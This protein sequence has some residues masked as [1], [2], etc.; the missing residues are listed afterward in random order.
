MT[1]IQINQSVAILCDG[2]NVERS[3][4]DIAKNTSAM[5]NFDK[6]IPK[7]LNERGLNRLIYFREGKNISDKLAE[8]LHNQYYG[9]V[10]PCHKSADI[11]LSIKAT[12]LASKVDTIIIMSGDSDY[13]DLVTHLKS[14]G[15]RVE[16]A[17]VR[18]TTARILI[19]EADY[20]HPITKED[21]FVFKSPAKKNYSPKKSY[22]PK[23]K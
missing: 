23:K 4:H 16:I 11:P 22:P 19:N 2:N 1:K 13:V 10:V 21:W 12:Q 7:L 15:V 5:V 17:A 6:L 20:F 3:I 9:S 14:E 8:R 18:E